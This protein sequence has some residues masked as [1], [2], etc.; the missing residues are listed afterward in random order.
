MTYLTIYLVGIVV[1]GIFNELMLR[2]TVRYGVPSIEEAVGTVVLTLFWPGQL[3][4][5]ALAGLVLLFMRLSGF[6]F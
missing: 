3:V 5:M 4:A 1:F 6:K 2:H